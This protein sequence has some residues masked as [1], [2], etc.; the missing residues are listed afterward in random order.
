M[1][2]AVF[3]ERVRGSF[4][5]DLG[6]YKENQ[7]RR[8]LDNLMAKRRVN[9]GD[10]AG[11][12]RLLAADRSAY[13]E[14]LDT[15][16]INISE[17]FRDK[18]FFDYLEKYVLPALSAGGK[19]LKI[20]S[21]ACAN[22]AEPYSFAIILDEITPGASHYIEGSD[23]DQNALN[24]AR[25]GCFSPDQ[26]RNVSGLRLL[27]YFKRDGDNHYLIDSIKN[28]VFFRRH[29]LLLSPYDQGFD[30]IACRNVA[31]YFN[32]VAQEKLYM[33]FYRALNSGGVLFIGASEMIFNCRAYGF[34]KLAPC[35]YRKK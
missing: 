7:L 13:K 27:K 25:E 12:F 15:L 26:I 2:F 5:L 9:L 10:Y 24:A 31:I 21:A 3:M 32:R 6:S 4:E 11:F 17:F 29:D 1:E 8:R 14:F 18:H 33:N 16:T 22:G 35:F 28:K 20:W 19:S 23:I 30:L 34:E